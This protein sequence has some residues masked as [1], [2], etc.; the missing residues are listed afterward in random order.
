MA[1]A[2]EAALIP[3]PAK[4]Q[5]STQFSR[6]ATDLIIDRAAGAIA[7]RGTFRLG[8]CGGSTPAVIYEELA[9]DPGAVPWNQT[10]ITFGDERCVP[11]DDPQSNFGN[12]QRALLG[13]VPIPAQNVLRMRGELS[14]VEAADDYQTTLRALAEK[15]GETHY[16]HDLLLLGLGHDGHTASLFPGTAALAETERDVVGDFVP[17]QGVHRITLT[18][19]LINSAR[20]ICFLVNDPA[21]LPLIEDVVAGRSDCPAARVSP[22]SG[23]LVWLVG[24]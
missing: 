22:G 7:A 14:P 11:P 9:R 17:A 24:G 18:F 4:V 12:A 15:K 16:V 2:G 23:A 8:L 13:R 1:P 21:K 19:P 5:R 3:M 6:D 10:V 20:E